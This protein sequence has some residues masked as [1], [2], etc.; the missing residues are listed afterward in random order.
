MKRIAIIDLGT[1]TFNLLIASVATDNFEVLYSAKSGVALGLGGINENKIS[2]DAIVRSIQA[3]NSFKSSCDAYKVNEIRA[4]GTSAIR[5]AHN[6]EAFCRKILEETSISIEV[7]SGLEEAQLIYQGVKWTHDF[8]QP[9]TIVD[10]GGGSTEFIFVDANKVIDSI[11]LNIGISR[12]YQELQLNDPLT[13]SDVDLIENWLDNHVKDKLK[14]VQCTAVIGASGAFET[15]YQVFYN[16]SFPLSDKS[17]HMKSEDL[18]KVI[19][20]IVDSTLEER[21]KNPLIIPIRQ[22]MMPIA[23]VK[24]N[25]LFKQLGATKFYISPYS[26]K[27]GAL[28]SYANLKKT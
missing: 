18:K 8:T 19:Q 13:S 12:M 23:A 28:Y 21:R 11:S 1:N 25:W 16:E 15:L 24:I 6:K 20:E 9:T 22:L 17:I 2:E 26:L 7:I 27:E 10:I 5:D 14:Q 4:F 3:L